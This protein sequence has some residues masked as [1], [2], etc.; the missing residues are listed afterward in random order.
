ME[1]LQRKTVD[2]MGPLS[3]LWN[4]LEGAKGAEEDAVQISINDL[5][6]Y[7]EQ[8]VL[9][10]GQS[11]NAITYH[12][13]LNVLGSVMNSQ[14]QVKSMLK[15]K[16]SL[17]QKHDQYLK[18]K[19]RNHIADTIKSKKQT[20]EI[21]M[22][23]KKPFSFSPSQAQRKCEG[24]KFFLIKIGSKKFHNGNQQQQQ[25]RHTYYG[26]TGSQQQRY[27]RCNYSTANLLQ[28][29][30][31]SRKINSVGIKKGSPTDKKIILVNKYSRRSVSRKIK[32]FCR[33][34]DENN[35]GS[36]HF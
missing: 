20:K 18:K 27:G 12:R 32:T 16:P 3:K 28:H 35:T 31:K 5:L 22:E 2:V 33:I 21:F 4:I 13:R 19:F 7:V 9:L 30:F 10:L 23:R 24:Q 34:L 1:K 15:E 29:G 25:Q 11:S 36:Q 17:L 26:Q 8:T 6:H 14:Y